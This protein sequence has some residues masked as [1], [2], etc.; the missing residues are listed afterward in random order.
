M[1]WERTVLTAFE[2]SENAMTSFVQE[3]ARRG[4]LAEAVQQARLASDLARTQ[5][6]EGLSDFQV[7]LDSDRT[8]AE[9]EDALAETDAAIA[10]SL[11]TLYKALGG[12]WEHLPGAV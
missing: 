1:Q 4:S 2:E 3:Q 12:G 10:T 9:L 11:V 5:Y 6:R 8:L 7:V